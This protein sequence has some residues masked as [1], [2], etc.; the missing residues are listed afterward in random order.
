MHPSLG[1]IGRELDKRIYQ[2]LPQILYEIIVKSLSLAVLYNLRTVIFQSFIC[3]FS[4]RSSWSAI[5]ITSLQAVRG[6]KAFSFPKLEILCWKSLVRTLS[7][8]KWNPEICEEN[9]TFQ[10]LF[11]FFSPWTLNFLSGKKKKSIILSVIA[12]PVRHI[13]GIRESWIQKRKEYTLK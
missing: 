12:K 4:G 7:I 13:S 9:Q 2:V 11:F 3:E 6:K 1:K 8:F 10:S 5:A